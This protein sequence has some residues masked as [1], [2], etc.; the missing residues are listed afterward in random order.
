MLEFRLLAKSET[1]PATTTKAEELEQPAAIGTY[2]TM[3]ILIPTYSL[4]LASRTAA[5]YPA[6]TYFW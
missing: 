2:P 5:L 4:R 1:S 6:Q 3:T